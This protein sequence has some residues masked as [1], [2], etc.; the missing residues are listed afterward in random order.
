MSPNELVQ[1]GSKANELSLDFVQNAFP[2]VL[3]SSLERSWYDDFDVRSYPIAK[4]ISGDIDSDARFLQVYEV[5]HAQ[6]RAKSLHLGNMQ[7][8][9]SSLRDGSHSLIYSVKSDGQQ[10]KLFTGVRNFGTRSK[11]PTKEYI[12]VLYKSLRSN[13]PGIVL[14]DNTREAYTKVPLDEILDPI[15]GW[16]YLGCITG[17]PS[18]RKSNHA[19]DESFTQ[20]IDRLVDALRGESYLLLVIAEPIAD[21]KLSE[22]I[23]RLRQMGTEVHTMVRNSVSAS[24]STSQSVSKSTNVGAGTLLAALVSV[25]VGKQRSTS[26]TQGL[27]VSKESLDKTAQY[28]EQQIDHYI[29]RIQDGRSLGFWDVGIYILSDDPHTF[30]RAQSVARSLYSGEHTYYEPIRVLDLRY[31]ENVKNAISHLQIPKLEWLKDEYGNRVN[32]PLGELYQ[33]LGT[34]LTTE[35]LSI[36]ASFPTR[37]V[38]G[39]KLTPVADFNLNPPKIEG[40]KIGQLMYRGEQ[41]TTPICI[42]P[43]SLT[44]HTFVTGLTGSGKT[45]SC[46]AL[47][48]DAYKNHGLNFLVIDP[49]K[50][51]YRLLMQASTD[52]GATKLGKEI[53]IFTL[54]DERTAPFRLNP[55]EFEPGFP[56][57]THIDLLKSVFNAAFPM[58][59]S[60]P[61]LLEEAIFEIYKDKGWD[62][63][64]S[65]NRFLSDKKQET[66]DITP[67]LPRLSDLHAKIDAVVKSKGYDD[68][69]RH[70]LTAALK[71]RIGS[72]LNGFKG[73]MLDCYQSIPMDFL[74]NHPVVLELRGIGDD[75][76]KAFVMALLFTRL[77]EAAQRH[78]PDGKLHHVTLIE[79]AHRLLRNIPMASSGESANPRGKTIEMFTDM[80]AE[81]RA[82]GE[83]FIIVD[84]MPGKLVPDVVKGSNLKIVH[85]LLAQ[86][87]RESVGTAM[88]LKPDQIDFLP[89]LTVGQAIVHSEELGEACLVKM[90]PV[91]DNL[92]GGQGGEARFSMLSDLLHQRFDEFKLAGDHRQIYQRFS[93]CGN[94]A[95]PCNFHAEKNG[96]KDTDQAVQLGRLFI[97]ALTAGTPAGV[98]TQLDLVRAEVKDALRTRYL[99]YSSVAPTYDELYCAYVH[100][101]LRISSWLARIYPRANKASLLKLQP[102]LAQ[103]FAQDGDL[104]SMLP[105]LR[106]IKTLLSTEIMKVPR[107]EKGGCRSCRL[108]CRFGHIFQAEGNASVKILSQNIE[109]QKKQ[110]KKPAYIADGNL[111]LA[112]Q[113]QLKFELDPQLLNFAAYCW[114]VNSTNDNRDFSGYWN[115]KSQG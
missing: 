7:N 6:D 52:S 11:L 64:S 25:G 90:D 93:A 66:V 89:R 115:Q 103:T 67:Y 55:F 75:D 70:D 51:E 34:P 81:M 50:R 32:H 38:P 65:T 35:E 68:R 9:I 31:S 27:S 49:A 15:Q 107:Q 114:V 85:R 2:L 72:L 28:C 113:K 22:T 23:Q 42:S 111:S 80:M 5:V 4:S 88:G 54:G 78:S 94:C 104:G 99:I 71:T 82:H 105:Q 96:W 100:L 59:A 101:S 14:S 58:Y 63:Q 33:S 12:D 76:E 98:K 46:L 41:L 18:L 43:K 13:Y 86:D 20:S 84:Q 24:Q 110:G 57:L 30:L 92:T 19:A 60:M 29:K 95:D 48:A 45:N 8:V 53:V 69:L 1:A 16:D 97:A 56:L 77:Y 61:Y 47:L 102:L 26:T 40:A 39:L 91:E 87:D 83:G 112:V 108:A 37:E 3:S 109:N 74:L 36:L 62:I 17:I 106:E 44:R 21:A 10:V 79:E 73:A